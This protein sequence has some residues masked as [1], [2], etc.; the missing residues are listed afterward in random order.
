[1]GA[2]NPNLTVDQIKSMAIGVAFEMGKKLSNDPN[3]IIAKH[4]V[5]L[6]GRSGGGDAPTSGDKYKFK[7][8]N[9]IDFLEKIGAITPTPAK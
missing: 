2:N 4:N 8:P 5:I 9:T 3:D 6:E 7:D 1:M